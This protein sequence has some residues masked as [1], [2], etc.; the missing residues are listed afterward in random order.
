MLDLSDDVYNMFFLSNTNGPAFF[1][2]VYI[3][4]LKLSL[5]TVIAIH[6]YQ[7]GLPE[8]TDNLVKVTQFLLLPVA[9][10]IQE[11]LISC[12]FV[13]A[14]ME[15]SP[16]VLAKNP[17][18]SQWKF[19]VSNLCRGFDGLYCLGI[20]F[21]VLLQASD[22]LSL[23]LN[24]AALQFLQT[25]D[26]VALHLAADGYLAE[27][28]EVVA[29]NVATTKLPRKDNRFFNALD[30]VL[31]LSTL[32]GLFAAYIAHVAQ[33]F[34]ASADDVASSEGVN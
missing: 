33:Q 32:G 9:V 2:A 29:D 24:F 7:E 15:Y 23:F 26:N 31:F 8:E 30:S 17:G 21:I 22:V 3:Y 16:A 12:F 4:L 6:L 18:A 27:R 20:N 5:Y 10:A 28:L 34:N 19:T 11:D 25:I 14:N 13:I 1:Y